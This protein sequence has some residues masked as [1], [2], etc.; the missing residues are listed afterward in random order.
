MDTFRCRFWCSLAPRAQ[1]LG[2][3]VS[4][5]ASL[6]TLDELAGGCHTFFYSHWQLGTDPFPGVIGH[7]SC[8]FSWFDA[9]SRH[10]KKE[11]R[12]ARTQV[13]RSNLLPSQA[14]YFHPKTPGGRHSVRPGLEAPSPKVWRTKMR[15]QSHTEARPGV[16]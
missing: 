4:R 12:Y 13:N 9:Q 11:G 5:W 14:W 10:G 1:T 2:L 15:S 8:C 6:I 16:Q 7:P 3:F